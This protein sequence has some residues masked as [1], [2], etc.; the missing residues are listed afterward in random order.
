MRFTHFHRGLLTL[1][2]LLLS[3]HSLV[4]HVHGEQ[5]LAVNGTSINHIPGQSVDLFGLLQDLFANS[6]LGEDHLEHFSL[7]H[8]ASVDLE[9]VVFLPPAILP[10]VTSLPTP[11]SSLVRRQQMFRNRHFPP[12]G[13]YPD[14]ASPRGPPSFA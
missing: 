5:L 13:I 3:L 11:A 10:P 1:A 4:P 2:G 14:N 7:D 12:S 8:D 6:D 9:L